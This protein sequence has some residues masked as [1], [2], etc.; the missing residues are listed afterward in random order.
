MRSHASR[1]AA[2]NIWQRYF[3]VIL[4]EAPAERRT[5]IFQA[6]ELRLPKVL[7]NRKAS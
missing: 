3:D 7:D 6:S 2:Q 4:S 1:L 5:C